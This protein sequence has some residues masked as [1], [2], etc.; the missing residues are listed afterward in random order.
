[1]SAYFERV[2]DGRYRPTTH[3]EGAWSPDEIHFGPLS[4]LVVHAIDLHRAQ[5]DAGMVLSRISFDILGFLAADELEISVKTL[6]PGRTIE[7]VAAT[8]TIRGRVAVEARAWYLARYDTAAVE[9]AAPAIDG[10]DGAEDAPLSSMWS[11]G[12]VNSLDIRAVVPWAPGRATVWVSTPVSLV[13]DEPAGVLAAW[14]THVDAANGIAAR[15]SPD[16]WVFPNV[17]LTIHLHRQPSGPWTG[18]DT[19]VAFG[20]TGQGVVSTSLYDLDGAV[21]TAQQSLTVRPR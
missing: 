20:P 17:D 8:V 12:Y 18:L 1:M 15:E 11:G 3:A 6:R 4:G 9:A 10:P 2:G 19:T 16:R 13:A 14:L 5:A 7:L 21:G